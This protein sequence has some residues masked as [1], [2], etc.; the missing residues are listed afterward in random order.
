MCLP[1]AKA[2]WKADEASIFFCALFRRLDK[3]SLRFS[4]SINGHLNGKRRGI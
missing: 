4:F 1:T 2:R 3:P